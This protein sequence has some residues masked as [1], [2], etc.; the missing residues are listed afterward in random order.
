M[1][2]QT[3]TGG[4]SPKVM[5]TTSVGPIEKPPSLETFARIIN[6][7]GINKI[8]GLIASFND[9]VNTY[10]HFLSHFYTAFK[11]NTSRY[12]LFKCPNHGISYDWGDMFLFDACTKQIAASEFF[13]RL[14]ENAVPEKCTIPG[15]TST[16]RPTSTTTHINCT[17][18]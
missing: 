13:L 15:S 1:N 11:G 2:I 3:I 8:I 14:V 5:G 9:S 16:V 18:D 17:N 12:K 7:K 4:L 10:G 6:A